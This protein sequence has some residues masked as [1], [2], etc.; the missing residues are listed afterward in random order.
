[1]KKA[2]WVIVKL[3]SGKEVGGYFGSNSFASSGGTKDIYLE[4]AWNINGKAPWTKR[5]R[6]A[7]ILV[8]GDSI[9]RIEFIQKD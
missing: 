7:G 2:E 9:E 3:K 4:Q 8:L 1:M 6:S 5:D